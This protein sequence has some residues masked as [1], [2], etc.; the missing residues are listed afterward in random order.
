M[1]QQLIEPVQLPDC[2]IDVLVHHLFPLLPIDGLSSLRSVSALFYRL[3]CEDNTHWKDRTPQPTADQKTSL[4]DTELK[5]FFIDR[6]YLNK[7]LS[8]HLEKTK[9]TPTSSVLSDF[10]EK[11]V[12]PSKQKSEHILKGKKVNLDRL[13]AAMLKDDAFELFA[14]ASNFSEALPYFMEAVFDQTAIKA[15]TAIVNAKDMKRGEFAFIEILLPFIIQIRATNCF[16]LFLRFYFIFGNIVRLD[17]L[18][19]NCS[20]LDTITNQIIDSNNH[21]F[22]KEYARVAIHNAEGTTLVRLIDLMVNRAGSLTVTSIL[23]LLNKNDSMTLFEKCYKSNSSST[24]FSLFRKLNLPEHENRL[25]QIEI[26]D[27]RHLQISQVRV[28]VDYWGRC[29]HSDADIVS[30]LPQLQAMIN[31]ILSLTES[32]TEVQKPSPS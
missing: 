7:R 13:V 26:Q 25:R 1:A 19:L 10:F 32:I 22:A 5:N 17:S 29:Y 14:V 3:I 23:S 18:S 12:A 28:M 6:H 11:I 16:N 20:R 27:E 31:Q 4:S 9:F 2:P 30:T 21:Y 8:L 24:A 15:I